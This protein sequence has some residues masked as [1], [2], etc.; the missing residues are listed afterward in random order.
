ML[1]LQNSIGF[2][3]NIIDTLNIAAIYIAAAAKF[4]STA[5]T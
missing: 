1:I 2:K 4:K 3:N 5:S